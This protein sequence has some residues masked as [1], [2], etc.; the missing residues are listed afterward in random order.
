MEV[1]QELGNGFLEAVYQEA[2]EIEF[3]KRNIL[4]EREKR[5]EIVYKGIK[6]KKVYIADFVCFDQIILEI[7]AIS[8]LT[9]EHQSQLLNYLSAAELK[10]G[11]LINFG[12]KSLEYKRMVM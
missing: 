6:L 10:V 8:S 5:L 9:T 3:I 4:F 11:L 7:K 12:T 1:H 2:L